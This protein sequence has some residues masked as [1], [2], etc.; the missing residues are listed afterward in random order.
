M[1]APELTAAELDA[2]R[3]RLAVTGTAIVA[4]NGH[5]I[6]ACEYVLSRILSGDLDTASD[7]GQASIRDLLALI[8]VRH[9]QPSHDEVMAAKVADEEK[10]A[11]LLERCDLPDRAANHRARALGLRADLA[12]RA[13]RA[14]LDGTAKPAAAQLEQSGLEAAARGDAR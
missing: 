7:R 3:Q 5:V 9:E 8:A 11:E 1:S 10:F 2:A 13:A 4:R 12:G 6:G 14:H